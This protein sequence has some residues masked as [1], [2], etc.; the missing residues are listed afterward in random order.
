MGGT[1]D[2]G[3]YDYAGPGTKRRQQSAYA[4]LRRSIKRERLPSTNKRYLIK[5]PNTAGKNADPRSLADAIRQIVLDDDKLGV[6]EI[7]EA[8]REAGHIA[9]RTT[10]S[11]IRSDTK[12][13]LRLLQRPDIGLI[14]PEELARYRRRRAR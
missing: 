10:I 14:D 12:G 11:A 6:K 7:D 13:C 8:L 5:Q 4:D 3:M 2:E 1:D 9:S